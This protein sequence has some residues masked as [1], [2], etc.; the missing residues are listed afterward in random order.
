MLSLRLTE[1]AGP[2]RPIR[3]EARNISNHG[4]KIVSNRKVPLFEEVQL[5][6]FSKADGRELATLLGKVVRVEEIDIG[7]EEMSYGI[8]MDFTSGADAL[9]TLIPPQD[10]S[11]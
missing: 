8:A 7:A 5:V 2:E 1:P 10:S 11:A 9:R 4:L 6:L 3:I